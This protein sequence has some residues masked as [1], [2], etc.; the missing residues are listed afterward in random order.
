MGGVDRRHRGE[1]ADT[2]KCLKLP[3]FLSIVLSSLRP[4][5]PTNSHFP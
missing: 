5:V 1:I 3:V 2:G 4:K